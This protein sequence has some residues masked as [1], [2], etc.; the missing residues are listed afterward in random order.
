MQDLPEPGFPVFD[1]MIEEGTPNLSE[2]KAGKDSDPFRPGR[3]R[4][5]VLTPGV[6]A[7]KKRDLQESLI[8]L[9]YPA[10]L[11]MPTRLYLMR[12]ISRLPTY[13][14]DISTEQANVLVN[15]LLA[16]K[17]DEEYSKVIP[18]VSK[19][20][21]W[22]Q[23]LLALADTLGER[24]VEANS[25]NQKVFAAALGKSVTIGNDVPNWQESVRRRLMHKVATRNAVRRRIA[26]SSPAKKINNAA[27]SLIDLYATRAKLL[28]ATPSQYNNLSSPGEALKLLVSRSADRAK[29]SSKLVA[30][31]PH[32]LTV[33]DYLGD[34]DLRRTVLLQRLWLELAVAE[35]SRTQPAGAAKAKAVID[36]LRNQDEQRA[37]VVQQLYDGERAILE[38]WMLLA[39]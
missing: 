22:N 39:P 5:P 27:D 32:R 19:L 25:N 4:G 17:S 14:E 31:L 18:E 1:Q 3:P 11:D 8:R 20:A 21:R 2:E 34:N 13:L 9:S 36:G 28:G 35:V 24:D 7:P 33:V 26:A 12:K 10:R 6:V 23:F 30:D 15:Y 29:G 37:S 16:R 38:T